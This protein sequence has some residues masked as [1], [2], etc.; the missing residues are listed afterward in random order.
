M[1]KDS[2]RVELIRR[3]LEL[4]DYDYEKVA[5]VIFYIYGLRPEEALELTKDN[6]KII[7]NSLWIILPTV[8]EGMPRKIELDIDETPFIKEVLLPYLDKLA[9]GQSLWPNWKD[10][11]NFNHVFRK[12]KIR[13]FGEME[14]NPRIFRKFRLSYLAMIGA[15]VEVLQAWKGARDIRSI[16]P[17]MVSRP[18]TSV[19]R[20]I[21]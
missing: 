9:E 7:G 8:K 13:S 11:T 18:V 12:I 2:E 10:P 3:M 4:L 20:A 17:Y 15:S 5:V 19:K 14:F 6:F 1:M 16:T 21:K